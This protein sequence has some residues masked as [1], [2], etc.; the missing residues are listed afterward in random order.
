MKDKIL[1]SKVSLTNNNYVLL[2]VRRQLSK[3]L[4]SRAEN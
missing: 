2:L 4:H 3:A 1:M